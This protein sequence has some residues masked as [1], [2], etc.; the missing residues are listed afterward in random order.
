MAKKIYV[1]DTSVYLT[2]ANAVF[3]YGINDIVVPLKVLEEIDNHKKRQDRERKFVQGDKNRQG[4][5]F[6]IRQ[7]L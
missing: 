7:R 3:A 5:R 4:Q 2:D 6:N 1:L